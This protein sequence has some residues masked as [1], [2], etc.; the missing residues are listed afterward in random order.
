MFNNKRIGTQTQLE[1]ITYLHGLGCDI[2]EPIGDNS[3][4]DFIIDIN[5]ILL[6]VQS[7]TAY[8]RGSSFRIPCKSV[9][10][11]AKRTVVVPYKENSVDLFCTFIEGKCYLIEREEIGD[12]KE[13]N[14]RIGST[15]N[16][17]KKGIHYAENYLA[18]KFVTD[19]L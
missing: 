2:S 6:R 14:I 12:K 18:D 5:G 16:G 7:K 8:K 4:Y 10:T 11:N 3:R 1:C 19:I 17:Q 9:H 15:N 13:F